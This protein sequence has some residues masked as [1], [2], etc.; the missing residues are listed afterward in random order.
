[1]KDWG[2]SGEYMAKRPKADP[3]PGTDHPVKKPAHYTQGKMECIDA[4]MGL[5]LDP[6]AANVL[7]YIV[8]FRYRAGRMDLLKAREYLDMMLTNY[9]SWYGENETTDD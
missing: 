4:I 3:V 1:M 2:F 6:C 8:R 7:K 9:S 5:E